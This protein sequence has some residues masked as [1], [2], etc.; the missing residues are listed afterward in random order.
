MKYLK[1]CHDRCEMYV[2]RYKENSIHYAQLRCREHGWVK[3]MSREQTQEFADIF[4][5]E[6]NIRGSRFSSLL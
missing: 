2:T 3:W 4:D 5:T 6:I 1:Q